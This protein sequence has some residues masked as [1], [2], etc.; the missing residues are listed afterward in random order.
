MKEKIKILHNEVEILRLAVLLLL[1]VAALL[2]FF[3]VVAAVDDIAGMFYHLYA[4][5]QK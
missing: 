5:A 4:F 2:L 1:L 3:V